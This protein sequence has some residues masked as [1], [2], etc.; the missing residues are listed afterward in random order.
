MG[1]RVCQAFVREG[2]QSSAGTVKRL[3][4]QGH[5]ESSRKQAREHSVEVRE[6]ICHFR[7]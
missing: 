3:E 7:T 4:A 5:K 6:N 2:G 1:R